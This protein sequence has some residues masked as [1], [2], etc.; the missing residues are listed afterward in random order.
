M[1]HLGVLEQAGLLV[2]KKDGRTRRLYCNAVP[3]RMI[4][5]RWTSEYS[6][7]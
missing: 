1:K 5:E 2:S 6:A 7:H 4:H 3:I